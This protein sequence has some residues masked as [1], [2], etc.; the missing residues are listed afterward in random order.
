[1]SLPSNNQNQIDFPASIMLAGNKLDANLWWNFEFVIPEKPV[2]LYGLVSCHDPSGNNPFNLIP[3]K[4]MEVLC[5][6]S[7]EHVT[8]KVQT[9]KI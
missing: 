3:P 5:C 7:L 8:L 2:H 1:M 9:L 4:T 6:W